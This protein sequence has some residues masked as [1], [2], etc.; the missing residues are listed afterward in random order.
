VFDLD[1]LWRRE[2]SYKCKSRELGHEMWRT[3]LNRSWL[4]FRTWTDDGIG[5]KLYGQYDSGGSVRR[6]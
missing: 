5:E 2:R 4:K 3:I 6:V 1:Q